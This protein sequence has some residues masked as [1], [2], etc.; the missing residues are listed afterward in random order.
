MVTVRNSTHF[1]SASPFL[2]EL[3]GDGLIGLVGSN[4]TQ[5][6][7]TFGADRA[8]LGNMPFGFVAPVAEGHPFLFDFCCAVMSFGKLN[9]LKAA[10]EDI[11]A[12]AF[13]PNTHVD[14]DALYTNAAALE[15]LALPFGGFKGG[16]IAMMIETLSGL[17]SFGHYGAETEVVREGRL[18]GP[19]HFVLAIDPRKFAPP[20]QGPEAYALHMKRYV[21]ELKSSHPDIN[22]AGERAASTMAD[23]EA[24]GIPVSEAL[25]HEISELAT[26]KGGAVNWG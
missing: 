20:D 23:R 9:R 6:M 17:L 10:G 7:A 24:H 18:Q 1:G 19:S 16:N 22:Y 4:S 13:K 26:A 14:K 21:E 3:L 2:L 12:G 11:P 25:R 5:S 15:N 8:N